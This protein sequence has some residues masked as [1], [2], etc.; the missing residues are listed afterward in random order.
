MNV[1]GGLLFGLLFLFMLMG[2]P[3]AFSIELSSSFTLIATNFRPL[4][5]VAQRMVIGADSFPL[6]AVPLFVLT[7]AL[8][9]GGGISRRLVNWADSLV[10]NFT[11]GLGMVMVVACVVFAALTGSGPATVAAIGSILIPSMVKKGYNIQTAAGLAAAAGALGPIIPPSIPMII[12]GVTANLSIPKMFIGGIVPGLFIALAL[13]ITNYL[14]CKKSGITGENV[15]FSIKGFLLRTWEAIAALLLPIIIL[16]G[17]YGG[18]F[19]PTEAAAVGVAYSFVVG[20]IYK[21]LRIRDLGSII[22]QTTEVSTMVIFIIANAN[23]LGWIMSAIQLPTIIADAVISLIHSKII[24]IL[25]LNALLFFVGCIMDTIAAIIILAPIMVPIGLNFGMDPLHLG[26]LF[27]I[28]LVIGYVTP[29]FGY[30]LFTASAVTNLSLEKIIKGVM[31]FLIVEIAA[32]III[33]FVPQIVTW[34][35]GILFQ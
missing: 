11:G 4:V 25:L 9:E 18:I 22:V 35:P 12:Y 31:P 6:L 34:L 1:L 16:G 23:L 14:I 27:V 8:M 28:N 29:P 3:I 7:G 15:S 32:V 20:L 24:Y 13:M 5:L 17:I 10:G 2:I 26:V 33:A 21:E 19:T 30:N